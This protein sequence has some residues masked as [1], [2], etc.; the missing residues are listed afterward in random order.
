M[1]ISIIENFNKKLFPK[2]IYLFTFIK[3]F[4]S[5]IIKLFFLYL[6]QFNLIFEL[7]H[8]LIISFSINKLNER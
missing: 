3:I 4:F 8:I 5:Y 7:T 2:F 6:K 1:N